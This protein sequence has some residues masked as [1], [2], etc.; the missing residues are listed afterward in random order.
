[1]LQG[2]KEAGVDSEAVL[3]LYIQTYNKILMDRPEGMTIGL[4]LCRGNFKGGVHFS[5]GG[6][7]RIAIK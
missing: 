2:M 1:M 4:H 6:Y 5:E 7:D 3:D